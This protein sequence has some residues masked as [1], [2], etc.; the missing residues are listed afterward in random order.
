M[1][2]ESESESESEALAGVRLFDASLPGG[3]VDGHVVDHIAGQRSALSH[4]LEDEE[5]LDTMVLLC[6]RPKRR[7]AMMMVM[8][9]MGWTDTPSCSR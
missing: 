4:F 1:A 5:E 6:D 3:D 2:R 7:L 9:M 8:T